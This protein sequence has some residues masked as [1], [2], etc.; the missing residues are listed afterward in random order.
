MTCDGTLITDCSECTLNPHGKNHG[1]YDP[2]CRY[3][4]LV[5]EITGVKL[6]KPGVCGCDHGTLPDDTR[7]RT[8]TEYIK[9]KNIPFDDE[10]DISPLDDMGCHLEELQDIKWQ[11]ENE[12]D[13]F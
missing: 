6:R 2:I 9:D 7:A 5:E 4:K 1:A 3:A 11:N 13:I 12:E 8:W 10:P